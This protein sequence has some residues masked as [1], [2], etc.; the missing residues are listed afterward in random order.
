MG[1]PR[2]GQK[3]KA[4]PMWLGPV[5]AKSSS[6]VYNIVRRAL[7]AK[8]KISNTRGVL[9]KPDNVTPAIGVQGWLSR[10]TRKVVRNC[11]YCFRKLCNQCNV[12]YHDHCASLESLP[13]LRRVTTSP[14]AQYHHAPA[15]LPPRPCRTIP[16]T[17]A[18]P[19]PQCR[20]T[21]ISQINPN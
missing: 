6:N 15:A 2:G 10:G 12:S 11:K 14:W 19:Q 16:W 21:K 8:S 3:I 20:R 4:I 9:I 5:S 1:C 13:R 17:L 18:A 7:K